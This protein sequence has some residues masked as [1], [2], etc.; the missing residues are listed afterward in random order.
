MSILDIEYFE[1]DPSPLATQAIKFL[2]EQEA[3][4]AA[5][6][7]NFF[8]RECIENPGSAHCRMYDA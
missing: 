1:I 3:I 6:P 4:E 7:S 2:A 5:K 8:E